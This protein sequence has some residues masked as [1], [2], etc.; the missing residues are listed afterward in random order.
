[1]LKSAS[2]GLRHP[3]KYSV[4]VIDAV[5]TNARPSVD[6]VNSGLDE[7]VADGRRT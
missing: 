5:V 6:A 3:S 1:M 2:S 7:V 4:T